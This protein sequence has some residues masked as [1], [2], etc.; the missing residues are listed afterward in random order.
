MGSGLGPE[1]NLHASGL[2][3]HGIEGTTVL[4]QRIH[5]THRFSGLGNLGI[6]GRPPYLLIDV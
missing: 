6:A 5:L 4:H 3:R 1:Y 2:G